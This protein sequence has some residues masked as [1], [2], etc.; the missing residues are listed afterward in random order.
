MDE[1]EIEKEEF[2]SRSFVWFPSKKKN[3]IKVKLK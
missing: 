3:D 2:I 1:F